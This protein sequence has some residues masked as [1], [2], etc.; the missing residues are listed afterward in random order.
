MSYQQYI[1]Y[2]NEKHFDVAKQHKSQLEITLLLP[3]HFKVKLRKFYQMFQSFVISK[4]SHVQML[5][6]T[7]DPLY[8]ILF[9]RYLNNKKSRKSISFAENCAFIEK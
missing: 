1:D 9:K 3:F 8:N 7:T 4:L 2:G 5:W 6:T